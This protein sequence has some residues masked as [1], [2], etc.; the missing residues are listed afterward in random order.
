MIQ[1]LFQFD[2][3]FRSI[4]SVYGGKTDKSEKHIKH[5]KNFLKKYFTMSN[6]S[7]PT[8]RSS[9]RMSSSSRQASE[10]DNRVAEAMDTSESD[11]ARPLPPSSPQ[12]PGS[13]KDPRKF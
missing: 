12:V 10:A 3:N 7:T 11:L 8:R 6:R 9:N 1:F 4:K 5:T 13:G 2:I